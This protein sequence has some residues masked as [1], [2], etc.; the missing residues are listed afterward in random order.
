[1]CVQSSIAVLVLSIG[2]E[3]SMECSSSQNEDAAV[4]KGIATRAMSSISQALETV[5]QYLEEAS[6]SSS[7]GGDAAAGE[8]IALAAA[9]LL[10]CFALEAPTVHEERIAKLIPF[11]LTVHGGVP[12]PA[13]GARFILPLLAAEAEIGEGDAGPAGSA[14]RA[15]QD[16]LAIEALCSFVSSTAKELQST[17]G[18]PFLRQGLESSLADA[19]CVL[20]STATRDPGILDLP[21]L[22]ACLVSLSTWVQSTKDAA[23]G[24][25]SPALDRLNMSD[26]T[27]DI[28]HM[29][30]LSVGCL[31]GAALA[32]AC[33]SATCRRWAFRDCEAAAKLILRA[34]QA[35]CPIRPYGESV[36]IDLPGGSSSLDLWDRLLAN[37]TTCFLLGSG[38]GLVV[39]NNMWCH[40]AAGEHKL[41]PQ[42]RRFLDLQEALRLLMDANPERQQPPLCN[43]LCL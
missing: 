33:S 18:S 23:D 38:L 36:A 28:H 2:G 25:L 42:S 8:P 35:C 39:R 9:R 21:P 6:G 37:A 29:A 12:G 41:Q 30:F 34:L 17:A 22:S 24:G 15:V 32:H 14:L 3:A 5:V 26:D 27:G 19:A 11:V 13:G 16:P 4:S 31:A 7:G 40:W 20:L 43:P 1:M 10:G